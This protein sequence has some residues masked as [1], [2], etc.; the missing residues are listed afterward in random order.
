M[1]KK[2]LMLSSRE[3]SPDGHIVRWY[4]AGKTYDVS[5]YLAAIFLKEGWAEEVKDVP[6]IETPKAELAAVS[7]PGHKQEYSTAS[8]RRR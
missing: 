1:P 2:L 3:G 8:K 7:A 4:L 5:E 6:E